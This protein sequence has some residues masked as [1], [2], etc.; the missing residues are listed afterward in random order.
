MAG[1]YRRA[2]KLALKHR[3][4]YN[5]CMPQVTLKY[6]NF[7]HIMRGGGARAEGVLDQMDPVKLERI[8]EH[9]YNLFENEWHVDLM[10]NMNLEDRGDAIRVEYNLYEG[11]A[12]DE[13]WSHITDTFGRQADAMVRRIEDV[14]RRCLDG[15]QPTDEEIISALA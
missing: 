3:K 1:R 10:V 11:Q 9:A 13:V 14:C 12:R 8:F 15:W 6:P 7:E 5:F 2:A 4:T